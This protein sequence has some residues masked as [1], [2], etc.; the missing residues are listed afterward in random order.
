MIDEALAQAA[1]ETLYSIGEGALEGVTSEIQ[2]GFTFLFLTCKLSSESPAPIQKEF[3]VK[4]AVALNRLLP[5]HPSQDLGAWQLNVYRN[6]GLEDAIFP[7]D[8]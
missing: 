8:R 3:R 6:G 2:D 7:L 4:I 5:E 1:R